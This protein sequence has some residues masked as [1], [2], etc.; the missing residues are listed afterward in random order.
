MSY[1]FPP[2]YTDFGI[3]TRHW[4]TN[5][6]KTNC[7]LLAMFGLRLAL[8]NGFQCVPGVHSVGQ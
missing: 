1:Y 3:M 6:L 7:L 8:R 4:N 2:A 5:L